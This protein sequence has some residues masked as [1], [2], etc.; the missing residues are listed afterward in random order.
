MSLQHPKELVQRVAALLEDVG[1]LA[2]MSAVGFDDLDAA[3][4]AA[5]YAELA[6]GPWAFVDLSGA[7][8]EVSRAGVISVWDREVVVLA[9]TQPG[10]FAVGQVLRAVLDR[11][12]AVDLGDG[13]WRPL[14]KGQSWVLV[15]RGADEEPALPIPLRRIP[16]WDFIE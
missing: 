13:E 2:T 11:A 1:R 4:V 9:V 6:A 16:Y 14:R 15:F 12:P 10:S 7:S 5:A 3:R 8:E